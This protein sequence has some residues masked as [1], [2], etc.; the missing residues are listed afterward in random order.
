MVPADAAPAVVPPA[1]APREETGSGSGPVAV[2]WCRQVDNEA[3]SP[4]YTTIPEAFPG[5]EE[6]LEVIRLVGNLTVNVAD[7]QD[8]WTPGPPQPLSYYPNLFLYPAYGGRYV[9][10]GRMFLS[11]EDR[12]RLGMKTL[13]LDTQKLLAT[14]D[15]GAAILHWHASMAGGRAD[16]K[17]PPV[18]NPNLYPILGEGLLFHRG[19]SDPVLAVA[20]TEWESSME[21]IFDLIRTL[22]AALLQLGA[23]LAFPYFLPQPKTNLAE[24]TEEVPLALAVMRI[25]ESEARG[26]RHRKRLQSWEATSLTFRDLTDGVPAPAKGKESIPLTLQYIR[27]HASDKIHPIA[28]RVDAVELPRLAGYLA[29]PD[30]QGGKERRKEMMRIASAMESAAV[31]LTKGKA[32]HVPVNSEVARRAQA[33]LKVSLGSSIDPEP[34]SEAVVGPPDP[35]VV[36]SASPA[37]GAHP[38]WLSRGSETAPVAPTVVAAPATPEVVPVSKSDDDSLQP[39][40]P[41]VVGAD[42]DAV[43]REIAAAQE[44]F[45][46]G[47][48]QELRTQLEQVVSQRVSGEIAPLVQQ[49]LELRIAEARAAMKVELEEM[50]R[51]FLGPTPPPSLTEVRKEIDQKLPDLDELQQKILQDASARLDTRLQD[52]SQRME[53]RLSA[54]VTSRVG[55]LSPQLQAGITTAVAERVDTKLAESTPKVETKVSS[56]LGPKLDTRI[57]ELARRWETRFQE[58]EAK[59]AQ[60]A[61]GSVS[62]LSKR[63]D[64][65]LQEADTKSAQ[66]NAAALADL[67]KKIDT[68]FQELETKGAQAATGSVGEVSRRFDARLQELDTKNAQ[69]SA[70]TVTDLQKR[71]D[72]RLQELETKIGQLT[73][74]SIAAAEGRIR[75]SLTGPLATEI[76]RRVTTTLSRELQENP[77]G[78]IADRIDARIDAAVR[79]SDRSKDAK[80]DAAVMGLEARLDARLKALQGAPSAPNA[81]TLE[82]LQPAIDA[83]ILAALEAPKRGI[84]E[85]R[86]EIGE[87]HETLRTRFNAELEQRLREAISKE[88]LARATDLDEI[89][90]ELTTALQKSTETTPAGLTQLEERIGLALETRSRELQNRIVT[91][92][93]EIEGKL[94]TSAKEMDGRLQGL[95]QDLESRLQASGEDRS[96]QIEANLTGIVESRLAESR[97]LQARGSADL[98]LRVQSYADQKLRDLEERS[99]ASTVELLGRLRQEVDVS[100]GRNLDAGRIESLVK[101]RTQRAGDALRTEIEHGL[102]RRILESE[103][104]TEETLRESLQRFEALQRDIRT[105]TKELLKIEQAMHTEIDDL[106]GRLVALSDRLVPVVRKAWLR[107]AEIEKGPSGSGE[108]EPRFTQLKRDMKEDLRKIEVA[109]EARIREIRDRTEELISRQGKVWLNIIRNLSMLAADRSPPDSLSDDEEATD[110]E[111]LEPEAGSSPPP[112]LDLPEPDPEDEVPRRRPRRATR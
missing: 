11:T 62:E 37:P 17:R 8:Y 49:G 110:P 94:Q 50:L 32:K 112:T 102:E 81:K 90:G 72:T 100:M 71:M 59:N 88:T 29:D 19:E 95:R 3:E 47:R 21:V 20:S 97:E 41:V 87:R 34:T 67:K 2:V 99:R 46:A 65:R 9:C 80:I 18:P 77:K 13:V 55:E 98:Q 23:V 25:P 63:L 66:L 6:T 85:L 89:R 83:R 52:V 76:D 14:G 70:T 43:R 57:G 108:L 74:A 69:Q 45:V 12:P 91:A 53:S 51:G 93:K 42:L 5:R 111:A 84:E 105:Q 31:L 109:Q 40:R 38:S 44:R 104:R 36:A 24:F 48:F 28:Q 68:R 16:G 103:Q 10:V 26:D 75:S 30:R 56:D 60:T 92:S 73:N 101:E 79:L 64:A 1:S 4:G 7:T 82:S 39:A 107:I 58:L 15:Y 78:A 54:Q 22:P 27:D 61:T 86:K 35:S 96:Q 33:Y 106:D